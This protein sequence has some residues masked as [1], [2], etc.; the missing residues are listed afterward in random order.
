MPNVSNLTSK[1]SYG[2]SKIGRSMPNLSKRLQ[3][4]HGASNG[5]SYLSSR[6]STQMAKQTPPSNMYRISGQSGQMRT[7][8]ISDSRLVQGGNSARPPQQLIAQ[9]RPHIERLTSPPPPAQ[10]Y[11]Q[12]TLKVYF[13]ITY[14]S[15]VCVFC[16]FT[17]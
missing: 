4:P 12:S 11:R 17:Y 14:R 7:K 10:Q 3:Q 6:Q 13:R 16:N 8:Q 5:L 1:G 2:Q 15:I 9:N